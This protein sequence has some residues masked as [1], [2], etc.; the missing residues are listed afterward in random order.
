ML[1]KEVLGTQENQEQLNLLSYECCSSMI[2]KSL[3][4]FSQNVQKNKALMDV[5][6]EKENFFD[7]LLIQE[8][9]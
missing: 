6:L 3:K 5:I 4:I 8:P 9:S 2:I 1:H 7:I